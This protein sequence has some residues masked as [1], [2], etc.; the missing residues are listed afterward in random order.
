M[1]A[2]TSPSALHD[3]PDLPPQGPDLADHFS[4]A[5]GNDYYAMMR[6]VDF[7]MEKGFPLG[8]A[9]VMGE[10]DAS[11][12]RQIRR[13]AARQADYVSWVMMG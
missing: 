12:C 6:E 1:I 3:I 10:M 9:F 2:S 7:L 13:A 8:L 11:V 4:G 5:G